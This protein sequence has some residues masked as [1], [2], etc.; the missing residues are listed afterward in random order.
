M[1]LK[2]KE[3][4]IDTGFRID[5]VV[6][7]KIVLEIKAIE[8]LVPVHASQLLTYLKI[9]EHRLGFIINFNV[10]LYQKRNSTDMSYDKAL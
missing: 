4:Q 7:D 8:T 5:L 2:Y 1:P 9:A 3:H 10:T 6:N